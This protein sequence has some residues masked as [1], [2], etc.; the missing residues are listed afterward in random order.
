VA[1]KGHYLQP[2]AK[3]LLAVAEIRDH[4]NDKARQLLSELSMNFPDNHLYRD[5]LKKL[6]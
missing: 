5:E 3:L 6:S 1:E 2:Y 4:H